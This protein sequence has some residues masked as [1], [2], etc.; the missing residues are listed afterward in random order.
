[1]IDV[2]VTLLYKHTTGSNHMV[3]ILSM[4]TPMSFH[5]YIISGN[6]NFQ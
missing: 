2:T 1:M 6:R 4:D 3:F 5:K